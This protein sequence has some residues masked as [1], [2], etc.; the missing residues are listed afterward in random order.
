MLSGAWCNTWDTRPRLQH[1]SRCCFCWRIMQGMRV[2]QSAGAP[3]LHCYTT[4]GGGTSRIQYANAIT[5]TK[6]TQSLSVLGEPRIRQDLGRDRK[7]W[8]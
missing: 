4:R 8:R 2:G 7:A 5:T 1:D 3:L 6:R